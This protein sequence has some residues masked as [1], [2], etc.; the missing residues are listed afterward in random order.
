MSKIG[1]LFQLDDVGHDTFEAK[2]VDIGDFDRINRDASELNSELS[3]PLMFFDVIATDDNSV[4][5]FNTR[6]NV[7]QIAYRVDHSGRPLSI[8]AISKDEDVPKHGDTSIWE[9]IANIEP[10]DV[11]DIPTT[12]ST[13]KIGRIK[14]S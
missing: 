1:V 10:A 8:V 7:V 2:P 4:W 14:L 13:L 6:G 3:D 12:N 11:P 5:G 9:M